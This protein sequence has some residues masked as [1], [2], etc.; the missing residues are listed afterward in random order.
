MFSFRYGPPHCFRTLVA[1]RLCS[2]SSYYSLLG[3]RNDAT[4]AEIKSAFLHLSKKYHPDLNP[5]SRS[6]EAH[7]NFKAISEAYATLI[8]PAKRSVYDRTLRYGEP[9]ASAMDDDTYGFYKPN[10]QADAY[11]YARTYNY[12]DLNDTEWDNLYKQTGAYRPQKSHYGVVRMLLIL[13]VVGSVL[14]VTRFYFIHKNHMLKSQETTRKNQ[15]IYRA[16]REKGQTNT[17]HKQLKDLA[18]N[19]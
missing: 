3:L 2:T 15:E 14:H 19:K 1:A 18:Q 13:M 7:N 12:Y 17:V 4:K 10:P 16:V 11:T 5:A 6:Q 8:D 9:R